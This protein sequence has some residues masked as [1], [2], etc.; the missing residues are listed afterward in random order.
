MFPIRTLTLGVSE[1][2]PLAGDVVAKAA[3]VL[4]R[5]EATCHD[6]G[7]EVQTLRLS[8]RPVFQ[9]MTPTAAY[10]RDLQAMLDDAELVYCSLG[11]ATS[12]VET[13]ADLLIGNDALNCTVRLDGNTGAARSAA[14]VM[15]RLANET[16]EGFGNFRF[17]A[18]A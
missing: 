17:A 2:H 16:E 6:T 9:D 12:D 18:L 1:P 3:E 15:L 10:A 4:R 11:P 5:A 7:Y 13:V 8:T 14:E